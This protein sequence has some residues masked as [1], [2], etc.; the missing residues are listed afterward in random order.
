[1]FNIDSFV[2]CNGNAMQCKCNAMSIVKLKMT[3]SAFLCR[4]YNVAYKLI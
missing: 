4:T 1:M 3:V 2:Y